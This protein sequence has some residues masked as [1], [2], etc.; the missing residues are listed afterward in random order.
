M[1]AKM[2]YQMAEEKFDA[3]QYGE[4]L[5]FLKKAETAFGGVNP[6]MAY[7]RVMITDQ[8]AAISEKGTIGKESLGEQQEALANLAAALAAFENTQGKDGLG[9][10]KLMEVYRLKVDLDKR[11][12]A[13]DARVAYL[14]NRNRQ[15]LD[16]VKRLAAG[17]PK[18]GT[19]LGSFLEHPIAY[20]VPLFYAKKAVTEKM[21][22]KF[23]KDAGFD[24]D[25]SS[26]YFFRYMKKDKLSIFDVKTKGKGVDK[27]ASYGVAQVKSDGYK[28]TARHTLNPG[29][30]AELLHISGELWTAITSGNEPL[31]GSDDKWYDI[32][33]RSD[34]KT[35]DGEYKR[36]SMSINKKMLNYTY[37]KTTYELIWVI[38]RENTL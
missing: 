6:P 33:F 3:K 15:F 10:A 32:N 27:V 1:E 31:V 20:N 35:P 17:F 24:L 36:L 29:Q 34:E 12:E 8:V 16:M 37:G 13:Y 38:V 22:N 14:V 18:T 9:E 5:G 7:L 28:K 11:K 26:T 30:I 25:K 19:T 21:T 23:I 2:A 4:A